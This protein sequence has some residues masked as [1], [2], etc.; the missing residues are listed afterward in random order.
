M[1][2]DVFL[3]ENEPEVAPIKTDPH[4]YLV[5][6]TRDNETNVVD[7]WADEVEIVSGRLTFYRIA[8]HIPQTGLFRRPAAQ[9][10]VVAAFTGWD[11]FTLQDSPYGG[12]DIR[13]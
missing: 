13:F 7:V 2:D 11:Y 6:V 4:Q 5:A 9:R 10:E 1:S 12:I 3:D 8:K